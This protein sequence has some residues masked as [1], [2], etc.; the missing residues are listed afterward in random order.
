MQS[1]QQYL[2]LHWLLHPRGQPHY[3]NLVDVFKNNLIYSV[4]RAVQYL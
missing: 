2:Q 4:R 1:S 3:S